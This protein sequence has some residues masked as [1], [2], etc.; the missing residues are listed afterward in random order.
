MPALTHLT[1]WCEGCAEVL[2]PINE[3][4]CA[5]CARF[6]HELELRM[7]YSKPSGDLR[8]MTR[9]DSVIEFEKSPTLVAMLSVWIGMMAASAGLWWLGIKVIA[10]LLRWSRP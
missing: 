9:G 6:N 4:F 5:D 10:V 1:V 2:V 3:R 7:L 8:G